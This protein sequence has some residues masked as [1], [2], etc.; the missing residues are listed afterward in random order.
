VF[1]VSFEC[2]FGDHTVAAHENRVRL[3]PR[4]WIKFAGLL[5][6]FCQELPVFELQSDSPILELK[7]R[8]EKTVGYKNPRS[9]FTFRAG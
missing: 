2:P 5:E 7:A 9:L 3:Q 1:R 6:G 4:I 8:V